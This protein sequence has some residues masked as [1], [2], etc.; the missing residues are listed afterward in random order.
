MDHT[1]GTGVRRLLCIRTDRLG[2]VLLTLP[3]VMA[4][5]AS[6]PD[7]H[8][9]LM[10]NP[11]L[12]ALLS[13]TPG[14]DRVVEYR[15]AR[16]VP[17]WVKA[18]RLARELRVGRYDA[19]VVANPKKEFHLAAYWAG[20]PMRGGYHRKWGGLLTH[21]IPDRK[22][23]GACH[24]VEYNLELV[25]ALN[26]RLTVAL[27][28]LPVLERERAEVRHLLAQQGL[29][30]S[31]PFIAVHPWASNPRKQWPAERFRALIRLL[32][33]HGSLQVVVIGGV[34]ERSRLA[35][36]LPDG[37][38]VAEVVGRLTLRQLAAL[39]EQARLLV[40]NDSGPVHVAAAVGT[41]TVVLFGAADPAT[42]PRRWGPWGEGHQVIWKASLEEIAVDEV[43]AAVNAQ[44]AG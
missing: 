30:P 37:V 1:V 33:G 21:R 17:W 20:I 34:E 23:L 35:A 3:A 9:T 41:R 39:L 40:S 6:Y 28:R 42:G 29:E 25:Q 18:W 36:V 32:S 5:R 2:E 12:A 26:P 10:V 16:G 4:L 14:V 19:V 8:L 11:Q 43:L 15:E 7:C 31:K 38:R 22:A 24:E 13:G 27:W 44:L